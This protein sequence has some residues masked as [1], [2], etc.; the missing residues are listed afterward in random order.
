MTIP[1]LLSNIALC[2]LKVGS[3]E[4][5]T[6]NCSYALYLLS[7]Q[8]NPNQH[9]SINN[10]YY[11]QEIIKSTLFTQE[12]LQFYED[13]FNITYYDIQKL[14]FRRAQSYYNQG[15]MDEAKFDLNI[16]IELLNS[17]LTLKYCHV[18]TLTEIHHHHH[19]HNI[20]DQMNNSHYKQ[21]KA[22]LQ[23]SE[24]LLIKVNDRI[25]RDQNELIT[26]LKK[27]THVN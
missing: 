12:K 7:R 5:C 13:N 23:I 1:H 6:R 19:H 3:N 15:K 9:S 14:L 17:Q 20:N 26:R 22:A 8:I 18:N 27:R 11:Y 21:I 25:L 2:Q 4:Y 16:S 10:D 24:N